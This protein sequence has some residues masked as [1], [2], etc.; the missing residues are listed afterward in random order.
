MFWEK[1][2]KEHMYYFLFWQ[3]V[4]NRM[5]YVFLKISS[6]KLESCREVWAESRLC[7]SELSAIN[8]VSNH[9]LHTTMVTP[10]RDQPNRNFIYATNPPEQ[11]VWTSLPMIVQQ[12]RFVF[13][14]R[15]DQSA[16]DSAAPRTTS[17]MVFN[18][19]RDLQGK[20]KHLAGLR[21]SEGI[22]SKG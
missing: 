11:T 7:Q 14:W 9:Y 15:S 13:R 2:E 17:P 5:Y 16:E 3:E 20:T 10:N 6:A 18:S 12:G 19:C 21:V 22:K 8:L 1:V 4:V